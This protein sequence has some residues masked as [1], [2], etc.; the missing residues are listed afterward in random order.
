MKMM[1]PRLIEIAVKK[2]LGGG[3]IEANQKVPIKHRN[4]FKFRYYPQQYLIHS[5][6]HIFA[7]ILIA[8]LTNLKI[9]SN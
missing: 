9:F 8:N 6:Q 1:V 2:K 7:Y 4:E 5:L 3:L